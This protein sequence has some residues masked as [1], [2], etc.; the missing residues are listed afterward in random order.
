MR[1]PEA[2]MRSRMG[3]THATHSSKT[4]GAAGPRKSE[5]AKTGGHAALHASQRRGEEAGGIGLN[6]AVGAPTSPTATEKAGPQ[7]HPCP[8]P[9]PL[10]PGLSLCPPVAAGAAVPPG[11]G[12]AGEWEGLAGE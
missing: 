4:T 5:A 7:N 2:R 8:D 9:I 6:S 3:V 1:F 10:H 11:S 12:A